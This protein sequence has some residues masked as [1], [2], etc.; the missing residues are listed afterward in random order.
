MSYL[1]GFATTPFAGSYLAGSQIPPSKTCDMVVS[2]GK[3]VLMK[4]VNNKGA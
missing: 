1:G 3:A 4:V 2:N